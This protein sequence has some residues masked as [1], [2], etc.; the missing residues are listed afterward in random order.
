MMPE[1][2]LIVGTGNIGERHLKLVR[3]NYP[4]SKIGVFQREL[5]CKKLL[6]NFD[7][8]FKS[9]KEVID[10]L[11]TLAIVANPAP[12]HL[13]IALLLASVRCHLLIEKPISDQVHGVRE[14]IDECKSKKILLTVG[15]NLR[16]L[17]SL[18]NFKSAVDSGLIGKIY[19]IEANFGRN[20]AQWRPN[21]DYKNSVTAHKNLGGGVLLEISHEIDYL[22]WIFGEI[23]WVMAD[24]RKISTLD[25]DTEDFASLNCGLRGPNEGAVLTL[26][27]DCFRCDYRRGCTVVG[28]LGAIK[29]DAVSGVVSTI[30]FQSIEWAEV[31]R[32]Q[33]NADY[34]Y[35][36]QLQSFVECI[37]SGSEPLVTGEDALRTLEV[38]SAA[39]LSG[40]TCRREVIH[41]T[42]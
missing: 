34:S 13:K 38:V 42:N 29:W 5:S 31:F 27:L 39:K 8:L 20:L 18:Q 1:R 4:L 35:E 37:L 25:M 3:K 32:D 2:I 33:I 15:Y 10:F 24:V 11:P 23:S 41:A 16:F 17:P 14:L 22:Q 30:N 26:V 28:E 6:D 40:K 9:E 7:F 19:H 21:I 12:L 36:R